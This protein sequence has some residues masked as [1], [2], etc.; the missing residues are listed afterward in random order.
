MDDAAILERIRK[1]M[2][3]S[4]VFNLIPASSSRILDI[5]YGDGNLL[6]RLKHQKNCTEL[7]GI[8]THK[9]RFNSMEGMLDGNWNMC[10]GPEDNHL[11]DKFIGYFNYIIMHDVLE[12]I[13]D[14]WMFLSYIRRYA[15]PECRLLLV[16][17]NAQYW[18]TIFS[19]LQGDFPYG[20]DGHYN[21][22]HIRWFT[23]KSMI[24][25]ALLAGLK[26][27]ECHL[28]LSSKIN[29]DLLG[30]INSN[31]NKG[32]ILPMPPQGFDHRQ[33]IN[34][35]PPILDDLSHDA[36]VD[37]LF[38]NGGTKGYL[39]FY[40]VKILLISTVAHMD[41]ELD[42]MTTGTMKVRRRLFMEKHA[43]SYAKRLPREWKAYIWQ[44]G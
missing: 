19:L 32:N 28:L 14:P 1:G 34:F 17:P 42:R 29:G 2:Q 24:E 13:Y 31:A 7:Y 44:P 38:R 30:F 12:H 25:M 39:G 5:G 37:V 23:P 18:Q 6:L 8:E 26:I 3:R 9:S 40:A 10:L 27:E 15:S 4:D 20:L 21:E 22:D 16:C 11:D 33:Y 35:F 43:A 41:E 36:G